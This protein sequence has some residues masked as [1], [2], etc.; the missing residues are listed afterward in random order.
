MAREG[1]GGGVWG[2]KSTLSGLPH[3]CM[4]G[5]AM[6]VLGR[7]S[8]CVG[9]RRRTEGAPRKGCIWSVAGLAFALAISARAALACEPMENYPDRWRHDIESN[10]EGAYEIYWA[11]LTTDQWMP[12]TW[13]LSLCGGSHWG[14]GGIGPIYCAAGQLDFDVRET[15]RGDKRRTLRLSSRQTGYVEVRP[16]SA[17]PCCV[18]TDDI[19]P[20][21]GSISPNSMSG[22][23]PT[24]LVPGAATWSFGMEGS[25]FSSGP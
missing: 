11:R 20:S 16:L 21:D 5:A 4:L 17:I 24:V 25:Q 9:R 6:N 19:A 13:M 14:N 2:I 22:C 18:A 7:I 23:G 12:T 3:W 8:F 10:V 1:G 15:L